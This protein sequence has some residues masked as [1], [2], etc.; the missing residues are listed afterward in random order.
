MESTEVWEISQRVAMAM[1]IGVL[2]GLEREVRDKP[3]GLRTIVLIS[4]GA[5]V[6]ALVSEKMGGPGTDR[7]R[8]AAQIVTG[9]G[10]LGAGAILREARAVYG[11]TTAATIWMAAA[12][13]MACGFGR[14]PSCP[15]PACSSDPA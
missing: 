7:T 6:F 8:I 13:G 4:V 14:S 11:L 15:A 12:L 9:V 2:V 1:V 5:C 3:A 10:F